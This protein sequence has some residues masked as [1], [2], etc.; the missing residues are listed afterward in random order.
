MLEKKR[1]G[2]GKG[3]R[4]RG[5]VRKGRQGRGFREGKGWVKEQEE[6]EEE[7]R[8][9]KERVEIGGKERNGEEG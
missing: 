3:W 1:G 9:V 5:K 7:G 4:V 6:K 2:D 8:R